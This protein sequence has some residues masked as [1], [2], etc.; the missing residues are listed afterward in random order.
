M[1]IMWRDIRDRSVRTKTFKYAIRA[2]TNAILY[3][4][5]FVDLQIARSIAFQDHVV[6]LNLRYNNR[7]IDDI[8][9]AI[10]IV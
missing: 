2:Y 9:G 1:A 4:P 8:L 5:Y 3:D 7:S 6:A 10:K